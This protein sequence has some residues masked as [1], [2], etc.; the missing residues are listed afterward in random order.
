[1]GKLHVLTCICQAALAVLA[2]DDMA[3]QKRNPQILGLARQHRPTFAIV[4][5]KAFMKFADSF[6]N[7]SGFKSW[8]S[9]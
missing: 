5:L 4:T 3:K 6:S 2:A 7:P 9:V 1:M 8:G